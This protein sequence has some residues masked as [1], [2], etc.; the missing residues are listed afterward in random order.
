MLAGFVKVVEEKSKD[1]K[2]VYKGGWL[3]TKLIVR[4]VVF[5]NRRGSKRCHILKKI[6]EKDHGWYRSKNG[7][8]KLIENGVNV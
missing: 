7:V 4:D 3:E 2:I 1:G 5:G 8:F 6:V